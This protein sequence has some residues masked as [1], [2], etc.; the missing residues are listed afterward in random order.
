MITIR[1]KINFNVWPRRGTFEVLEGASLLGCSGGSFVDT[2]VDPIIQ[3][4]LTCE[5]GT[6]S[7]TFTIEFTAEESNPG[8]GAENG[9]W[10]MAASTEDFVGLAGRGD[11]SVVHNEE[12]AW[13]VETL[14]G[15]IEYSP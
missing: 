12:T 13:G 7:G 9:P 2:P 11:F 3:K 15:Q 1:T 14:T 6:R 8:P 10:N 4:L 5:S